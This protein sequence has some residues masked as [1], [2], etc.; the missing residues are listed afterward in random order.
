[1]KRIHTQKTC[2]KLVDKKMMAVICLHNFTNLDFCVNDCVSAKCSQYYSSSDSEDEEK[3][4]KDLVDMVGG[5]PE[6]YVYLTLKAPPAIC[7]R[8]QFQILPIFQK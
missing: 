5:N 8:R 2:L 1:M 4:L 6:E 3:A 7:S